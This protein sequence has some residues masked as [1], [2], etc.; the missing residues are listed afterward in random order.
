MFWIGHA[1]NI[2]EEYHAE[3][4]L[5]LT[6]MYVAGMEHEKKN[7]AARNLRKI[8]QYNRRGEEM[9]RYCS[10]LQASRI[11]KLNRDV[12]D[13]SISGRTKF[14]RKGGHYFR[15]QKQKE[16]GTNKDRHRGDMGQ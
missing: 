7:W 9:A 4:R 10:I 3:I 12:I 11:L 1:Q 2:P 5:N 13:D 16:N 8:I 15:Y 6:W 14:T